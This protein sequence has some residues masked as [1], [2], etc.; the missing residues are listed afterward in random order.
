[1][2][3]QTNESNA[4]KRQRRQTKKKTKLEYLF[5]VLGKEMYREILRVI[6]SEK[7][8]RPKEVFEEIVKIKDA[9]FSHVAV[10][11]NRLFRYGI[12]E[13]KRP[14]KKRIA[15]FYSVQKD[16]AEIIVPLINLSV[17]E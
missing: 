3:Q 12:L 17:A 1:M 10:Y 11:L 9:S 15:V 13:K 7:S 8:L 2:K 14:D 16:F 4:A 5:S 6:A